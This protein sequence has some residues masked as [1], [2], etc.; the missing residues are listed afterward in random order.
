MKLFNYLFYILLFVGLF[1]PTNANFYIPLP[2]LLLSLNEF[3]FLLLPLVNILSKSENEVRIHHF[4][5]KRNIFFLLLLVIF[6]EVFIKQI[7]FGQSFGEAFKAIRIGLPLFSSL[8]LVFQGI[9]VDIKTLW[10]VLL[11]CIIISVVLSIISLFIFLPIYFDPE[12]NT[13][14][15]EQ[16][17]GR[18]FN[19]NAAFGLIGLYLLLDDKDKWYNQGGLVKVASVF[20][21]LA[22]ILAFNRTFLALLV[23]LLAYLLVR[24]FGAKVFIKIVLTLSVV[25]FLSVYSYNSNEIIQRQVDKRILNIILGETTIVESTIEDNREIIYDGIIENIEDDYWIIG[26]PFNKQ[27]FEKYDHRAKEVVSLRVT[28]TSIATFLLRYGIIPL[29]LLCFIFYFIYSNTGRFYKVL[30]II[31]LIASLNIDSLVRQNSIFFLIVVFFI[32]HYS[33]DKSQPYET[34]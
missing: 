8:V 28:D 16:T 31:F 1:L 34:T 11:W 5:L 12:S 19:A 3:A 33:E 29:I 18:V 21:V 4:K 27:I 13:N 24:N 7:V 14:V 25:L 6:N 9:R 20:S 22:L 17:Q 32:S 26:L 30:F 23:L 10:K 15:L 2:G